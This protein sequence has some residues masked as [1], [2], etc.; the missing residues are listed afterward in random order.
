MRPVRTVVS[1]Q[2]Q[3]AYIGTVSYQD[4]DYIYFYNDHLMEDVKLF[5]LYVNLED[6]RMLASPI[7]KID[8]S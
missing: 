8:F 4:S 3:E 2:K 6:G 7:K 1:G 5:K